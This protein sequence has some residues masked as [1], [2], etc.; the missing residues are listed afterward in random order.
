VAAVHPPSRFGRLDIGRGGLVQS[1]REKETLHH[2]YINGGFFIF[3][4]AFLDRLPASENQSLESTPLAQL[5]EDGQLCAFKHEG[6][7]QCMDTM[8][9]RET[10]ERI[11]DSGKAPWIKA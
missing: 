6:F 5:A 8:R 1:F 2:D 11:Y 4:R 9:D 10:L 3:Q 7:W